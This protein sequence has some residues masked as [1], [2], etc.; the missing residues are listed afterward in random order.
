IAG[1]PYDHAA[2]VAT[3]DKS[4]IALGELRL[5]RHRGG[6]LA[7]GG[8]IGYDRALDLHFTAN[9]FP[10]R[11]IPHVTALP[12]YVA[13]DVTGRRDFGGTADAPRPSGKVTLA[14]A[15]VRGIQLGSGTLEL[16]PG[17]DAIHMRGNFFDRFV[18]DGSLTIGKRP[19]LA[20][21]VL[22]R[23]LPIEQLFPELAQLGEI[24]GVASG[25][26]AISLRGGGGGHVG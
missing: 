10:L 3:L 17:G 26:V 7:A 14:G 9:R 23:G 8:R 13:G 20:A 12:V 21:S 4:G 25:R 15:Q 2:L 19:A 24:R 1:D 5:E 18:I 6:T 11:A 22:F 16:V